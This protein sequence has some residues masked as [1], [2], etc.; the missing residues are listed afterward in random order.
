MIIKY[1]LNLNQKFIKFYLKTIGLNSDCLWSNLTKI[2]FKNK[3]GIVIDIIEKENK[4]YS[5]KS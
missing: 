5:Y 2:L 4:F 1:D 3:Y